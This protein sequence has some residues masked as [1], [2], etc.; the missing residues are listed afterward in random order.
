[1]AERC[2]AWSGLVAGATRRA[3]TDQDEAVQDQA[4]DRPRAPRE[5]GISDARGWLNVLILVVSLAC[6]P[7]AAG[8]YLLAL[9]LIIHGEPDP[10]RRHGS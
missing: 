5:L 8:L 3:A 2:T 9:A 1:M 6:L 10:G 7:F 4:G